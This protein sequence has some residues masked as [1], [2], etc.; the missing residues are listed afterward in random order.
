MGFPEDYAASLSERG[1]DV[2]PTT[3]PDRDA[4]KT[5]L[6]NV[7]AWLNDLHPA[8]RDSGAD[9]SPVSSSRC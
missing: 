9:S 8:F 2:D 7:Q 5:G 6:G 1:I 4:V 3:I